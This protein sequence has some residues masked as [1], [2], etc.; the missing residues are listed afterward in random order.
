MTFIVTAWGAV[1][2]ATGYV[3]DWKMLTMCRV[4]L[5]AMEVGVT[6]HDLSDKNVDSFHSLVSFLP[7][8]TSFQP[9]KSACYVQ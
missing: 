9:G 2:L 1:S 3:K 7:W 4:F 6:I 8:S 5:G